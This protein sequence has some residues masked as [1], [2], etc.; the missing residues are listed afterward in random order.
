MEC[1][2][3]FDALVEEDPRVFL[4]IA[5]ADALWCAGRP[6]EKSRAGE[7]L[8]VDD[9]IVVGCFEFTKPTQQRKE[10]ALLALLAEG[11]AVE[12]DDLVERGVMNDCLFESVLDHPVDFSI[13]ESCFECCEYADGSTDIAQCAWSDHQDAFGVS[14][15]GYCWRAIGSECI[16]G[17][18]AG[19]FFGFPCGHGDE[20]D[21]RSDLDDCW[22][23]LFV[24]DTGD[25]FDRRDD[26]AFVLIEPRAIDV[27]ELVIEVF[28]QCRV[29]RLL[30]FELVVFGFEQLD[31]DTD[32]RLELV[33]VPVSVEVVAL[34]EELGVLRVAHRWGVQA[35]GSC[36]VEALADED[37]VGW[38]GVGGACHFEA[39]VWGEVP[40][41]GVELML[42]EVGCGVPKFGEQ[43]GWVGA[44]IG[45]D[46]CGD[47]G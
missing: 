31:R 26:A 5:I 43:S 9:K 15:S 34:A 28:E 32:A 39:Q 8:G 38:L 44:G 42:D 37:S 12:E 19:G 41:D 46:L 7:P 30:D 27:E 23:E 3:C 6:C 1:A 16:G 17:V 21:A 24:A 35:M 29:D 22:G 20:F 11:F 36:E 33:V 47:D 18:D 14:H 2:W 4:G 25:V 10:P 45:S 13:W 40:A